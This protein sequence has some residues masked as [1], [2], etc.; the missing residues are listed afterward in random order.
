MR[1]LYHHR[2]LG[3]GAEGIHI[4]EM[5]NAFRSL[6]HE[7]LVVGP[8]G[9]PGQKQTS[10]SSGKNKGLS[11]LKKRLNSSV[12]ELLELAYSPYSYFTL[13]MAINDFQPDV[14]YDRY[15]TFSAGPVMAGSWHRVPVIME[16][17]APLALERRSEPDEILHFQRLA[18]FLERWICTRAGITIA[19]STPLRN[20]LVENGVPGKKV[21]VMPN[22]ANP[23]LFRT[24]PKI[25]SLRRNLNIRSESV[26]VGCR[27]ILRQWHAIDM[28]VHAAGNL[29]RR[30]VPVFLLIVGD[31]P[32]RAEVE[33]TM[34]QA[35]LRER[36]RI[37]G[38]V[39]YTEVPHYINLFDIAVSPK[40]TFYASPMKVLEYMALGK[41]VV[42]PN[43]S[44]FLDFVDPGVNSIVFQDGNVGDL[45]DALSKLCHDPAEAIAI[46]RQARIKIERR[47]NW[48]WNAQSVCDLVNKIRAEEGR[49][50]ATRS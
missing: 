32:A 41:A 26:V 43:R 21:V 31:G 19:V 30:N 35:G 40:A 1:I 46:G 5:V 17:N 7:V 25:A 48:K 8:T 14:I 6:G 15:I 45:T 42:V 12:F 18:F 28:L 20:Y 27:G 47:L 39:P 29:F 4:Q 38:R 50:N 23:D 11:V 33:M 36:Y 10:D 37:T 44:N 3:D 2:T 16:V 24:R 13:T 34:N 9:E 22:G 49:N